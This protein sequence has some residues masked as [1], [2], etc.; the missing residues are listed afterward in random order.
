MMAWAFF[1]RN[2]GNGLRRA[3]GFKVAGRRGHGQLNRTLKRQ[4]E[5]HIDQ[6]GEKKE[7]ATDRTKWCDGVHDLARNMR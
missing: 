2:N 1:E 7:H 6:I 4:V 3:L 5:D